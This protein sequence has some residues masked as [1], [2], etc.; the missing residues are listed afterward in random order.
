MAAEG[1]PATPAEVTALAK[2]LQEARDAQKTLENMRR[3]LQL[4]EMDNDYKEMERTS[5]QLLDSYTRAFGTTN[6]RREAARVLAHLELMYKN[7]TAA[8]EMGSKEAAAQAARLLKE[9][10]RVKRQQ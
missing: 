2:N 4:V 8:V 10:E 1:E 9:L 5:L 7:R 3:E 6:Q